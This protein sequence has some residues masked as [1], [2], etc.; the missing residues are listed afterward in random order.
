VLARDKVCEPPGSS[1]TRPSSFSKNVRR[2]TKTWS[3]ATMTGCATRWSS[4]RLAIVSTRVSDW[5]VASAPELGRRLAKAG[6]YTDPRLAQPPAQRFGGAQSQALARYCPYPQ[7]QHDPRLAPP[8]AQPLPRSP[9]QAAAASR[10]NRQRGGGTSSSVSTEQIV[11]PE[12]SVGLL[13][14]KKARNIVELQQKTVRIANSHLHK[15]GG[16]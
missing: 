15:K 12:D 1:R 8:P 3:S 2:D 6:I 4:I 13:V 16:G 5:L 10:D 7:P 14:G 11:V 9:L